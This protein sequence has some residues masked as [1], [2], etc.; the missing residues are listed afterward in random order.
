MG[1]EPLVRLGRLGL[2]DELLHLGAAKRSLPVVRYFLNKI[3]YT[4]TVQII[5][6]KDF[7]L[8][9]AATRVDARLQQHHGRQQPCQR[10]GWR[11]LLHPRQLLGCLLLLQDG[12]ICTATTSYLLGDIPIPL[13]SRY[14]GM[15]ARLGF[16]G[17][18]P[19]RPPRDAPE[20]VSL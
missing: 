15:P 7:D 3:E 1:S 19:P 20:V 8:L 11:P 16:A 6:N 9:L 13:G 4:S 5:Q 12:G 2:L 14:G 18:L 10:H 17:V